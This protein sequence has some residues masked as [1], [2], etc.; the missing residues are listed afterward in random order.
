M[1]FRDK[2]YNDPIACKVIQKKDIEKLLKDELKYFIKRVQE[3]YKA[4]QNLK[5]P[6]IVQFLDVEETTNNLYLFFEYCEQDL[7]KYIRDHLFNKIP[8]DILSFTSQLL[9]ACTYY[10]KENFLHRDIKPANILLKKKILKI[11]DF[12]LATQISDVEKSVTFAGTPHYM[13]PEILR[14]S[15]VKVKDIGKCDV[16]SV[17]VTLYELA[18][19]DLPFG[20]VKK[21]LSTIRIL[22]KIES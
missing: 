21:D 18:T 14:G 19:G 12:G 11:A 8:E 13:A 9:S 6:N 4:L 5:H 17:G 22:E 16:W 1:A 15:S 20:M 7:E 10:T 2:N 3:E